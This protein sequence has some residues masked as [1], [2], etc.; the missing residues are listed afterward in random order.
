MSDK[1][2]NRPDVRRETLRPNRPGESTGGRLLTPKVP[3]EKS[4]F[5]KVLEESKNDNF[6]ERMPGGS[7]GADTAVTR[8]AVRSA[9]S[10]QERFGRPKEDLSKK[11]PKEKDNDR[12]D[13]A[14]P[15]ESRDVSAPRAKEA[16]RRVIGRSST[17]EREGGGEGGQG[18]QGAGTGS[19][20]QGRGTPMMPGEMMGAKGEGGLL[21]QNVKGRFEM[22]LQAAQSV[23]T[24]LQAT[25]PP[26][27]AKVPNEIP[28][29]VLDQLVQYCRIVTKTDG[30][31]E[32]DMQLHDEVF[33]GLQLKVSVSKGKVDATFT[34]QS[35]EVMKLFNARKADIRQAL[36]EKGI[37]VHSINV[38]MV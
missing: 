18:G 29:A 36:T 24:T 4:A 25:P 13:S 11:V 3:G 26:K 19:G 38:V 10:Y 21:L 30:D 20:R 17:G 23:A 33:K 15:G 22:E 31:K 12:D 1:V 14:K 7:Q 5:D 34:T 28:K 9:G 37:V 6:M 35:E 27:P 32:L 16:D 8:E 2:D